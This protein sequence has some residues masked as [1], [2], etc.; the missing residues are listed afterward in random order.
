VYNLEE[1]DQDITSTLDPSAPLTTAWRSDLLGGVVVITGR[2]AD[3]RP[4]LAIPN[5]AR[6]NRN[7]PAPPPV[8]PEPRQPG[9]PAQAGPRPAPPPPQS[10]VWITEA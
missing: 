9:Q 6:Y 5:F 10:V 7:P 1:V 4:L 3:G 8:P 2:F